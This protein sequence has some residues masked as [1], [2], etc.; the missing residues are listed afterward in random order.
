MLKKTIARIASLLLFLSIIS[1]FILPISAFEINGLPDVTNANC[2]YF[3]NLDAKK[4]ILKKGGGAKISPASSTK[5]MTGLIACEALSERLDETVTVTKEMIS[6]N[7]GTSMRLSAGDTLSIR[8]L[9]YASIC[10]GFND[11]TLALAHVC[12]GSHKEFVSLMNERAAELGALNTKYANPTGFDANDQYTTLEDVILISKAAIDNA[13]YM[14]ISSTKSKSIEFLNQKE[15][16]T[17][18]NRNGLI[19]SY[20]AEG[21]VN[22]S[23]QGLIAG[24]TDLGGHCVITKASV[25]NSDYLCI[26]MGGKD[27]E[28]KITS[29]TIANDLI[30]Y[31]STHLGFQTLMKQGELICTIPIDFALDG[32]KSTEQ[33]DVLNVRTSKD[34]IAFIPSGIEATR[35]SYRYY[36]YSERLTAPIASGTVVGALDF[37]IDG[38]YLT[39]V[40]LTVNSDVTENTFLTAM[41]SM[42]K[43][44]I[45]RTTLLILS[46]FIILSLIRLLLLQNHKRKQVKEIKLKR[47][48]KTQG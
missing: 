36:L 13:L 39:S 6:P 19:G 45:G 48:K 4:V 28:G 9:L 40:P 27:I 38:E 31:A 3:Y 24:M 35:L 21:Y 15:A 17:V 26:V 25:N 43:A 23:A 14:E 7:Q 44:V 46:F 20:Y 33:G 41:E 32:V 12:G 16:F 11:A 37:Y 18:H 8:S 5:I 2:V 42:K 34:V 47:Y 29:Y 30:S 1:C 10:G 22:K